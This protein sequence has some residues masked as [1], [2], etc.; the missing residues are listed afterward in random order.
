MIFSKDSV[1][2][3]DINNKNVKLIELLL[4]HSKIQNLVEELQKNKDMK[5]ICL[6]KLFQLIDKNYFDLFMNI[7]F[8][9]IGNRKVVIN[10]DDD[11]IL[12]ASLLSM[13]AKEIVDNELIDNF[14]ELPNLLNNLYNLENH[15]KIDSSWNIE[16]RYKFNT[17]IYIPELNNL[18]F[19]Y[20]FIR[21]K[22]FKSNDFVKGNLINDFEKPENINGILIEDDK[23]SK[24]LQ[25]KFNDLNNLRD[26][27]SLETLILNI[28]NLI[29]SQNDNDKDK[30]LKSLFKRISQKLNSE[31]E[32]TRI[33][34]SNFLKYKNLYLKIQIIGKKKEEKK[35]KN[36]KLL[37]YDL[38]V[39]E[40][41][42]K[43]FTNIYPSLINFL[44]HNH[45]IYNK[46]INEVSIFNF[47]PNKEKKSYI[48]LWLLCLRVLA[49][50]GNITVVFKTID[51]ETYKLEYDLKEKI[52]NSIN[53]YHNLDWLLLISP[54]NTHLIENELSERFYNFFNYLLIAISNF[55]ER[56][57]RELFI[58][59]RGF[60]F[61]IFNRTFSKGINDVLKSDQNL[62]QIS[63]KLSKKWKC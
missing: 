27:A 59:I 44:N 1:Q 19:L 30:D 5:L 49:N 4:K 38:N 42:T 12:E 6:Q 32:K 46:L 45:H 63:E 40:K 25:N 61:D 53:K 47:F 39:E 43:L 50:C 2:I 55:S 60:I 51:D 13:L 10:I 24:K 15:E 20:L 29:L 11:E 56:N 17:R 9:N 21:K 34:L 8:E 41:R 54:N 22:D 23:I 26:K 14:I 18:S 16:K 7:F 37:F 35:A 62:F 58:Y 48:P 52:I 31:S 28:G 33:L 36:E 57:R 3:D